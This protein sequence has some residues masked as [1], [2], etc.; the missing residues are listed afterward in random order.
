MSAK[1]Q[2]FRDKPGEKLCAVP[3]CFSLMKYELQIHVLNTD[4]FII[5]NNTNTLSESW[6]L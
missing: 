1:P 4:I 2:D 3:K 5:S 6:P